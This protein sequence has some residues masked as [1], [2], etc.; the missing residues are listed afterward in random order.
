MTED[1]AII[2]LVVVMIF[3]YIVVRDFMKNIFDNR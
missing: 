1:I 2:K 3:T